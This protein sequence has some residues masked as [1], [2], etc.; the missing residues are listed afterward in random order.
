MPYRHNNT[1]P[2][3]T[4]EPVLPALANSAAPSLTD[5]N[6]VLLSTNLSGELR[7][8][9]GG[10][11][12]QFA[13]DVA[14]VSGD[15]G[16]LAL[17]VRR[18]VAA[19]SSGTDG[20]YEPFSTDNTGRLRIA[21]LPANSG[22]DIG[23]VDVLTL[24]ALP[25]GTNNIG[26]VDVLTM[27]TTIVNGTV[28]HDGIDSGNP[29]KIGGIADDTLPAAVGD[30][31]RV[32]A[33]FDRHGRQHVRVGHQSAAPNV[34][35]QIHVPAANVV[36][37]KSQAAGGIGV[38]NVCTALTVVIAAT[39]TAPTAVNVTVNLIDG[40]TGGTTYLWRTTLSLPAT[41]G[42]TRGI[43]KSNCWLPGTAN[44]AMTLEF[45]AAGGANT[46]ESV[47]MEGITI[48]E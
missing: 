10:G 12:T 20:D 3:T 28:A 27:P 1:A 8:T 21:A 40:A 39:A 4:N 36:A 31:D 15:T 45:S 19:A 26:D 16:T 35:T 5:G 24:P 23:D 22:V 46:V 33:W 2:S 43:Q 9:G 6:L 44:T 42:E 29:Q 7:V 41:A 17:G 11:G 30:L 14:H 32:N 47:S 18:D 25:A 13:E 37:T 48:T 34:W 38:R